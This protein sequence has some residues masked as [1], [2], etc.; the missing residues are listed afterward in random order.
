MLCV[1]TDV[2]FF[3]L[4][5]NCII[6][7]QEI[8]STLDFSKYIKYYIVNPP[9]LVLFNNGYVLVYRGAFGKFL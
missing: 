1:N 3:S 2:R 5:T 4:K 9:P 6:L 7:T 8:F